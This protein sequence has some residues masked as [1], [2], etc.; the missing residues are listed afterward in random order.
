MPVSV[1][2]GGPKSKRHVLRRFLKVETEVAELTDS[3]RLFQRVGV[4]YPNAFVL[5]LVFILG[6]DRVIALF[7]LSERDGRDVASKE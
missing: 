3:K 2:G 7:D 5:E 1:G 4:Q 6:T